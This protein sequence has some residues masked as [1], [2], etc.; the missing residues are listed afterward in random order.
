MLHALMTAIVSGCQTG[1]SGAK[2][3]LRSSLG[4]KRHELHE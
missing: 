1:S 2:L 3:R 4:E